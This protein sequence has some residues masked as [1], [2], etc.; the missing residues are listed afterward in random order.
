LP[1]VFDLPRGG[2]AAAWRVVGESTS[3]ARC[4]WRARWGRQDRS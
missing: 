3:R 2:G 1:I 4:A